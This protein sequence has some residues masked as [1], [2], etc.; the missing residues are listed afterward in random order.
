MRL[1][2]PLGASGFVFHG[3]Q[4][5]VDETGHIDVPE[6][7]AHVARENHGFMDPLPEGAA[8]LSESEEAPGRPEVP[9]GPSLRDHL[10]A[11]MTEF[12]WAVPHESAPDEELVSAIRAIFE[13]FPE[14]GPGADD[15][16]PDQLPAQP[17]Q[18]GDAAA[19]AAP[20]APR[21]PRGRR[22]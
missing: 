16:L 15:H 5:D 14:T 8:P 17:A 13:S 21:P 7:A 20:A 19:P 18:P 12:G 9:S 6:H 2:A 3:T 22:G 4:Y 1:R 11:L 10:T